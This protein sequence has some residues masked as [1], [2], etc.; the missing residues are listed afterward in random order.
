VFCSVL[1][2]IYSYVERPEFPGRFRYESVRDLL[3]AAF[4]A[5][6]PGGRIVIRDGIEPPP[7]ERVIEFIDPD[8]PAV[9]SLFLKEWKGRPVRVRE[10]SP[11]RFQLAAN[12]AMEFL[13]K[14]TW[15]AESFPY[16]V[17]ECYG[18][19]TL[20][21]YRTALVEWLTGADPG[22]APRLVAVPDAMAS[23]LQP[24]YVKGLEAKV[25]LFDGE[26]RPATLPDSNALLVVEKI[27]S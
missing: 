3:R 27:A 22:F 21:R 16:E 18:I 13:Y 15:G 8:G 26:M 19:M 12:D 10:L 20:D 23:Y 1:H 24:G 14:Y 11:T 6:A 7:A 4:R 25:R 5:L 2:E 17:R 9:L